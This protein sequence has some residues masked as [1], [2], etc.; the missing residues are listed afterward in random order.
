MLQRSLDN[1]KE[2]KSHV[3]N[4]EETTPLEEMALAAGSRWRVEEFFHDAKRHLGMAD[5]ETRAWTSWHH[6]MSLVALA[7]LYVTLT[8]KQLQRNVP[9]L[10]L[11]MAVRVLQSSFAR[12]ELPEDAAI[13]IIE[14]HLRRNRTAHESSRKSWLQKH[15]RPKLEPL[16]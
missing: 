5:Y 10:T 15:K 16:L 3:S 14:Y 8:K 1:P 2:L 6:H 9:E 11:D 7:H 4:A 13:D 12:S